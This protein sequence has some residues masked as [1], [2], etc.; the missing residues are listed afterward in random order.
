MTK[1]FMALPYSIS[2]RSGP[3][4]SRTITSCI[5]VSSRCVVGSSIGIRAFSTS[6]TAPRAAAAS[7]SAGSP[8]EVADRP[9][10]IPQSES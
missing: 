4:W 5:I 3:E 1:S 2:A 8:A 6:S 7:Q 10:K 9:R